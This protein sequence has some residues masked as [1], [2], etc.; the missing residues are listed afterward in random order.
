[1]PGG[2][3]CISCAIFSSACFSFHRFGQQL[4]I[5]LPAPAYLEIAQQCGYL[6]LLS[7]HFQQ[8]LLQGDVYVFDAVIAGNPVQQPEIELARPGVFDIDAGGK[9]H[10]KIQPAGQ[11]KAELSVGLLPCIIDGRT[12]QRYLLFFDV[13]EDAF[14]L[15]A[16]AIGPVQMHPV[17][18]L[19]HPH[20]C[21]FFCIVTFR[22]CQL[23]RGE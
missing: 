15:I 13:A 19:F 20:F 23:L 4:F 14:Y 5:S 1:M 3:G 10:G 9:S 2:S 22:L 21:R 6:F 12:V 11:L 16:F 18:E 17:L 8:L 7:V